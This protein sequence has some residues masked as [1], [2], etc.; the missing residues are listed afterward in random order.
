[1]DPVYITNPYTH[2]QDFD[3]IAQPEVVPGSATESGPEARLNR[4]Y[5]SL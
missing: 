5:I 3:Q 2:E 1:M 4:R